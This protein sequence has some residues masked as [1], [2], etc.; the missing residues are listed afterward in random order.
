MT[1][2]QWLELF[3][4]LAD[5]GAPALDYRKRLRLK[6][7]VLGGHIANL[8]KYREE[9]AALVAKEEE[10][11]RARR[12]AADNEREEETKQ[13][14]KGLKPTREVCS[15]DIVGTTPFAT[16]GDNEEALGTREDFSEN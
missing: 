14:R 11:E 9:L 13:A 4:S 12:R 5:S 16:A 1:R 3:I 15:G 8:G 10:D 6:T 7:N 2:K